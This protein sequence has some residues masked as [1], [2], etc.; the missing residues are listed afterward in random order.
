MKIRTFPEGYSGSYNRFEMLKTDIAHAMGFTTCRAAKELAY[1]EFDIDEL[2]VGY[3]DI[4][5]LW[6]GHWPKPPED[7]ILALL[8]HEGDG[9]ITPE[10][11]GPLAERIEEALE[12]MYETDPYIPN[13][14]PAA[15]RESSPAA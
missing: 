15:S 3:D 5:P 7:P 9:V 4:R 11:A 14:N 8:M 13:R 10:V 2:L 1:Y 12:R 6:S